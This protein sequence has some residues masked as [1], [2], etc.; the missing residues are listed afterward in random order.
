M[1]K[2]IPAASLAAQHAVFIGFSASVGYVLPIIALARCWRFPVPFSIVV[3]Y[4]SWHLSLSLSLFLVIGAKRLRKVPDIKKQVIAARPLAFIQA[5]LIVIYSA[6]NALFLRLHGSAQ[7]AFVLVRPVFKYFMNWILGR[8]TVR[9]PS[10]NVFGL[11]TVRLFDALYQFKC[12]QSAGSMTSGVVIIGVDL[13]ENI[14]H[15]R[16]A[17]KRIKSVRQDLE[18]T[19]I[20]AN[21]KQLVQKAVIRVTSGRRSHRF[22]GVN[23]TEI[24][25][26]TI[27]PLPESQTKGPSTTEATSMR[28]LSKLQA[29]ST[30]AESMRLDENIHVLLFECE[31]LMVTE[32]IE[33]AVPM[34]YAMYLSILFHLPNARFYPELHSLDTAKLSHAVQNIATYAMLE[35]VSLLY[36]HLLLYW[37]LQISAMH[38]LAN[39][40]ERENVMLQGVFITWVIVVLQFTLQ[41]GGT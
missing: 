38:L 18:K 24:P 16:N 20:S 17:H 37:E 1:T 22:L 39:I 41:H 29:L 2:L 9:I 19:D 4:P 23:P 26:N 28:T 32:F 33:C 13:I 35:F 27:A 21:Y 11:V 10:A 3:G 14:Y 7:I 8:Y 6:Y 31:R 15:L 5:A 36:M 30:D 25:A 34:L 40:L 12:M